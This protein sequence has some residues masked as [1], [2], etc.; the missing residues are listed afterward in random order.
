MRIF[1]LAAFLSCMLLFSAKGQTSFWS[2]SA[3][4]QNSSSDDSGSVTLGLK[5][6]S[7]VAGTVTG[8]RFYKGTGNTG[9]HLGQLW[10]SS[11]NKLAEV[12]FS[13]ETGSGWQKANF[14][15]PVTITANTT[16][17]ISYF[18]PVG[19][20]PDGQYYSWST[21]SAPPLRLSGSSP[22]VY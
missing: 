21:V 5:F 9:T 16:Y 22:G 19:H 14:G 3:A 7:D 2:N 12:V 10:S 15:T 11:G 8:V 20:Y 4:P 13:N 1:S 17:V 6:S 18:A